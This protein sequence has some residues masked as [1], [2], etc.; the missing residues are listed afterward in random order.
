VQFLPWSGHIMDIYEFRGTPRQ[1]GEQYGRAVAKDI[2]GTLDILVWRT[3][4]EPLPRG[5]ADFAAWVAGQEALLGR[6]WPW[7][8]EEMH[9]VAQGVGVKYE[10]ILL[11]NLRA[12]QYNYYGAPPKTGAC[13]SLAITL[14]DGT[15]ASGGALD[16]PAHLYCGP[17]KFVPETGYRSISFPIT[18]TSWGNRGMNSAGLVT[19][20]SSQILLG[21]TRLPHA[22]NQDL[23][24][25]AILQT[26][27]TAD[28]VRQLC[29]EHPFT[30]NLVCTD[31]RGGMFCAHHT[32]AGLQEL[33]VS[34]GFGALTNHVADDG[35]RYWLAEH[36]VKEFPESATTRARRGRLLG[37]A[38]ERSG[39]CT[40]D[41][42]RRF[43]FARND[44]D[45][46]TIHNQGTL[47][48][49]FANSQ[50]APTTCWVGG[51][52]KRANPTALEPMEV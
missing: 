45:D 6:H 2:R 48:M 3:G 39:Q 40:A 31:A 41:E 5:D 17:V 28:D 18:G 43:L 37:F 29:R 20:I 47:Y 14:A 27:A 35:I 38:R 4:Y 34:E 1:I 8:L 9:G 25:R 42:V 26:C 13:S 12:W 52:G 19:G 33:P 15:V 22:I 16:D 7:M 10:D 30:M 50:V 44:D 21:L 46:G 11:L 36:G 24:L 23:A 51:A 49:T 32:A